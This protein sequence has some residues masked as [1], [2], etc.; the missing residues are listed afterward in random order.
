ML[1]LLLCV[2]ANADAAR[3]QDVA[4]RQF[5]T[6]GVALTAPA[7]WKQV[8]RDKFKTIVQWISSDSTVQ[9]RQAL[10][11]VEGAKPT[12]ADARATA[13]H[14]AKDWGGSVG[15]AQTALAGEPAWRI[16]A[17]PGPGLR[18]VEGIVAYHDGHLYLIMGGNTPGHS[19]HDELEAIR[20]S[21]KWIPLESCAKHVD[22]RAEPLAAFDGAV[23]INFPELMHTN[24]T[25][26]PDRVL[27]LEM[28]DLRGPAR[29]EFLL[30]AQLISLQ[31]GAR[32]DV[33]KDRFLPLM[34]KQIKMTGELKWHEVKG[35]TERVATQVAHLEDQNQGD[36]PLYAKFSLIKI[37]EKRVVLINFTMGTKDPKELD[38][39]D[40][41]AEQVVKS[42][43]LIPP[44]PIGR[45][46]PK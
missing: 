1:G 37:D 5:P 7:S 6:F 28:S 27:D 40:G 22:F 23:Q 30:F 3:P 16:T 43:D 29:S 15:P 34:Q 11:M 10:I 21:W 26:S 13:D 32:F 2:S 44:Q 25:D 42:V 36:H 41:A 14:M 20:K 31:Q 18:P 35:P 39:F 24:P 19:C 33:A 8:P 4:E 9:D 12:D 46:A 45:A 38:A 17:P